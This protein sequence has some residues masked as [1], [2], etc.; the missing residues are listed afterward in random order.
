MSAA[1]PPQARVRPPGSVAAQAER[2]VDAIETS[3]LTAST[4][5]S[6]SKYDHVLGSDNADLTL[7]E[8]GSYACPYCRAANEEVARLRDRFGDRI[9]YV[10]RQRPITGSELARRA[11]VAAETASDEDMFW[12][13]H[14]ELMS[15][16]LD[17]TEDDL[18][19]GGRRCRLARGSRRRSPAPRHG[20]TPM[21]KAR[22]GAACG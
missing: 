16:S 12:R 9:R 20:W 21:W 17:L 7:V 22:A 4:G 18:A 11:A 1:K 6:T 19:G 10:F 3:L 2:G 14:V 13:A 5:R 15:R 8:Y